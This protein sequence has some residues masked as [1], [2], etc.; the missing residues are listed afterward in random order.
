MSIGVGF[1]P[2]RGAA[3]AGSRCQR[4]TSGACCSSRAATG[5]GCVAWPRTA[6]MRHHTGHQ[7]RPVAAARVP[8]TWP[9]PPRLWRRA[10]RSMERARRRTRRQRRGGPTEAGEVEVASPPKH[11]SQHL[12]L[13]SLARGGFACS[14]SCPTRSPTRD[15]G[16][17]LSPSTRFWGSGPGTARFSGTEMTRGAGAWPKC[18]RPHCVLIE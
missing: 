5:P 7:R 10:Q 6:R 4:A 14:P 12:A 1:S 2:W 17:Q 13:S 18:G 11:R 3:A 9:V 8:P 16:A 15:L